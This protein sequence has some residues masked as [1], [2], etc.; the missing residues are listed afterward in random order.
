V[1]S[2]DDLLA[3]LASGDE[4]RA[5]AAAR[6]LAEIGEPALPALLALF[7]SPD[8]D[9]RWWAVRA[10]A[11]IPAAE[12]AVFEQALGDPSAEVRQAG[13]LAL[14]QNPRPAALTALVRALSDPDALVATL[15]GKSLAAI[16]NPAVPAL[17]ETVE[18]AAQAARIHALQ[19]LA[20]IRDPRAIPVMMKVMDEG[21]AVL[22]YWAEEGL[23][24]LGLNMVYIK[25]G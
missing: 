22:Q 3:E 7:G 25:P 15:A 20:E 17:I 9:R 19:A 6:R 10:L 23:G 11:G 18:N 4:S 1:I 21:S 12:A 14:V 8:P 2:L 5:E 13:A 24:R 16:G